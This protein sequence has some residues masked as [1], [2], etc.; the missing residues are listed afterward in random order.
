MTLLFILLILMHMVCVC[1]CIYVYMH[2]CAGI[3][4]YM[5]GRGE[6][7]LESLRSHHLVFEMESLIGLELTD[8]TELTIQHAPGVCC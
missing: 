5:G 4:V 1:V 7:Q 2:M 8:Q 3:H 6:P